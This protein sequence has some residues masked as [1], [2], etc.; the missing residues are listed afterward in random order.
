[1]LPNG[2]VLWKPIHDLIRLM[3]MPIPIQAVYVL[4]A[5]FAPTSYWFIPKKKYR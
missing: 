1:M 5:L 2:K 4:L 3:I